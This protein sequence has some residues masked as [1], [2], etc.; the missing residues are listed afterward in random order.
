[1]PGGNPGNRMATSGSVAR[2]EGQGI[3]R[4][5]ID[6]QP[7][8]EL[9]GQQKKIGLEWVSQRLMLVTSKKNN[10]IRKEENLFSSTLLG[11]LS[12]ESI[13][14]TD[15]RQINKRKTEI[16]INICRAH[17]HRRIQQ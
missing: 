3:H 5:E 17:I 11:S 10:D 8:R 13:N 6:W 15:K 9:L 14:E 12:G 2:A 1:M 7:I 4:C 16:F